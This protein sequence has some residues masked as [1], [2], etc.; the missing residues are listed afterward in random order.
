MTNFDK[1]LEEGEELLEEFLQELRMNVFIKSTNS[2][3][4]EEEELHPE[5]EGGIPWLSQSITT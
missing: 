5:I 3:T 1:T 4:F 2:V